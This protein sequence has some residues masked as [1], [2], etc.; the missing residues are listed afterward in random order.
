LNF[1]SPLVHAMR[2]ALCVLCFA[3]SVAS[4]KGSDPNA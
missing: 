4:L 2:Y 3:S 1:F